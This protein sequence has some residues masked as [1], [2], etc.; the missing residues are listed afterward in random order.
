MRCDLGAVDAAPDKR[1]SRED[2]EVS[3]CHLGGVEVLDIG[4]L[5][6]LR[7]RAIVAERIGQPECIGGITHVFTGEALTVEELTDHCFAAGDVAVT[8]DPDAAVGF[9]TTFGDLLLDA[10]ENVG[11]VFSHPVKVQSRGL[12]EGVFGIDIHQ[13]ERLGIR[14]CALADGLIDRPQPGGIHV[15]VSD[16]ADLAAGSVAA[17]VLLQRGCEDLGNFC[18]GLENFLF[19]CGKDIADQIRECFHDAFVCTHRDEVFTRQTC[20]LQCRCNVKDEIADDGF[21]DG[22]PDA[23]VAVLALV[24]NGFVTLVVCIR[25]AFQT[26]VTCITFQRDL[27]GIASLCGGG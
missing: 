2:V 19:G 16:D 18:A 24:V 5:H 6:D 26:G 1:I 17:L 23:V 8:F 7:D 25:P 20:D 10:F 4:L 15:R 9:I 11:V 12:N 22:E 13:I 21:H 3:P 27:I 14:S